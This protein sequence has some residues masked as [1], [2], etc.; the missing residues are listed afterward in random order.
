MKP[1]Q[2]KAVVKENKWLTYEQEKRK[3]QDM[4]LTPKEYE[5]EIRKLCRRLG[6]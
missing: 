2:R 5:I 4:D 3:L 6:V 1:T